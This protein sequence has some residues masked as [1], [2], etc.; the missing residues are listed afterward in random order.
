MYLDDIKHPTWL[1][2][3]DLTDYFVVLKFMNEMNE[4]TN[5]FFAILTPFCFLYPASFFLID[6]N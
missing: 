1:C 6:V 3:D 4:H 2:R 5:Q